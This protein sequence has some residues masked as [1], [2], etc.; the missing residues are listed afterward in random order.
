MIKTTA[1]DHPAPNPAFLKTS[2]GMF[3]DCASHD[4]DVQRWIAQEDPVSLYAT[5][6]CFSKEIEAVGIGDWDTVT[7]S[8][9]YPSGKLGLVD[10]SR[11]A[12][13]GYGLLDPPPLKYHLY[14][15]L[16]LSQING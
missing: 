9:K 12:T 5:G 10:V 15:P 8:L 6:S 14:S 13:Y 1:R 2:G 16:C 11:H 7:I 3:H 4:I